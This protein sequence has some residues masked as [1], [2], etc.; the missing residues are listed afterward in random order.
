M[1]VLLKDV[2]NILWSDKGYV[3]GGVGVCVVFCW[4]IWLYGLWFVWF[5]FGE[6]LGVFLFCC[7]GDDGVGR[8]D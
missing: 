8:G 2:L 7:V 4:V 5:W 6:K 3:K 1:L